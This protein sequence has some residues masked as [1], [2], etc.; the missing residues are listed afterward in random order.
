MDTSNLG[1]RMK[2]YEANT[3]QKLL[4]R[5]PII[6]RLDGRSFSKFTKGMNKPFD[7]K[8]REAMTE[9][10][11]YLVKETHALF[12]YTQSDEISLILYTD[13]IKSGST[14]FDGRVQKLTSVLASL[15]STKFLMEMLDKFP[16]KINADGRLPH[17]DA[18][19]FVLPSKIEAANCILWRVND[20]VKNS[21]QMLAQSEFSHK[22]L[23]GKNTNELQNK[24]F[25]EK[26]INWND[27]PRSLKQGDFIRKE[28]VMTV[29]TPEQLS[30]IPQDKIP[31][32][33]VVSRNTI[34]VLSMPSFHDIKNTVEFIFDKE[35]PI[36]T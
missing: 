5:L 29:L 20:A 9:T 6:V 22:E 36:I 10:A 8:F 11:K 19:A 31:E 7:L 2:Q 27:L 21:I 12:A 25:V 3:E 14:M 26:G 15:A 28:R 24:L 34:K 16:N 13:N 17:F 18:R 4:P 33:G 23:L 30:R 32:N 35:D 1:D